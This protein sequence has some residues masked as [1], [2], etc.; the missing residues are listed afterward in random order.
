MLKRPTTPNLTVRLAQTPQEIESAQR[1]RYRVF[2]EELGAQASPA[3]HNLRREID[4]Y[5]ENALHLCL[6]D[7]ALEA[8]DPENAVVGVYRLLPESHA[9]S[10]GGFYSQNEFD[11]APVLA[12]SGK[13]LELGRSC[14]APAH[15]GGAGM[16]MLWQALADFIGRENFIYL[17]GTASFHGADLAGKE[18]SLSLLHHEYLAETGK[19]AKLLAKHHNSFRPT[20]ANEI[21]R[22][23]A[24]REMPSLIK[25]YLRLGG[26]IGEGVYIDKAFNTVDVFV[27][28]DTQCLIEKYRSIYAA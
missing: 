8:I 15:R 24:M 25:A 21:S 18:A 5:D 3:E 22:L 17:F 6:F 10:L 7:Q 26:V 27:L 11:I 19:R 14:V 12:L 2:V 4:A 20:P 16:A 1:L 9:Q 13:K 23:I 28:M